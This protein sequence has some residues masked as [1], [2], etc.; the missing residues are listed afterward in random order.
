MCLSIGALSLHQQVLVP[1]TLITSD[2]CNASLC[3]TVYDS[4]RVLT[5]C[6]LCVE[7]T[8]AREPSVPSVHDA[9]FLKLQVS[10]CV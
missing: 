4:H 6:F 9:L 5:D 7:H 10:L 8:E 3:L 1:P 2:E